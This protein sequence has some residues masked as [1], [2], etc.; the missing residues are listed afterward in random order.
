MNSVNDSSEHSKPSIILPGE[1]SVTLSRSQLEQQIRL[2]QQG[3]SAAGDLTQRTIAIAL[4]NSI[5]LVCLFLAITRARG[6]AAL[7]NPNNK[8]DEFETYLHD[9]NPMMIIT[10]KEAN[11][12]DDDLIGAAKRHGC[13]IAECYWDGQGVV[14]NLRVEKEQTND[15]SEVAQNVEPLSTD[16]ALLLHTSGTTGRPKV[17]SLLNEYPFIK[18]R[19][20]FRFQVPLTHQ[21][22]DASTSE[23]GPP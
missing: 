3:L 8:E 20:D 2:L 11:D 14:L 21:N 1:Q 23:S 22:L 12:A 5:E 13:G 6:I 18:S 7:L 16:I 10:S 15:E 4:P 17:V 19:F 9:M